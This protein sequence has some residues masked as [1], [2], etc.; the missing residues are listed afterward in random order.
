MATLMPDKNIA[1]RVY[2]DGTELIGTA[3]VDLPEISFMTDTISG[4]GISGEIDS[5]VLGHIQAMTVTL[6]WRTIEADALKLMHIDG[7]E[8]TLRSSQQNYDTSNTTRT[9]VPVK[10]TMRCVPHTMSL[11]SLQ[12]AAS[13]ESST[14]LE[15]NYLKVD[16]NN[17]TQIEIDKLNFKCV[18]GGTD[19]FA[20]VA[21]D[22]GIQVLGVKNDR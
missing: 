6:N 18:V 2:K 7:C 8:L 19:L 10:I 12:P 14:E 5:P 3:T 20:Q 15:V 21:S 22:L 13:T 1:Y 17:E 11:G 16:V 4:A 9:T